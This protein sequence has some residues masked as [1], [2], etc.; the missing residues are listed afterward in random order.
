MSFSS[1]L[2]YFSMRRKKRRERAQKRSFAFRV[3]PVL[4]SK[5]VKETNKPMQKMA[6]V[7][8][9]S[10]PTAGKVV[11]IMTNLFG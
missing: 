5:K 8:E 4:G 11:Q 7:L 10:L 2:T 6:R 1:S 9:P 3:S